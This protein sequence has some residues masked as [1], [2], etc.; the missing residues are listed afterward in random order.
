MYWYRIGKKVQGINTFI[1]ETQCVLTKSNALIGAMSGMSA[2]IV[3][4][5]DL[6]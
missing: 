1:N 5:Q 2:T 4:L 6:N 3:C